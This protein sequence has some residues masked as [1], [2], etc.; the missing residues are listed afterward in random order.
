MPSSQYYIYDASMSMLQ[1]LREI[2]F[3]T[4]AVR[5]TYSFDNAM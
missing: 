1:Q 3:L 2:A 4:P 5:R